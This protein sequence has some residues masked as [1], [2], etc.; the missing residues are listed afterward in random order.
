MRTE[1]RALQKI[2]EGREAEM[3]A[4]DEGQVLRLYRSGFSKVDAERQALLLRAARSAGVRVPAVYDVVDMDGRAGIILERLEGTDLMTVLGRQPW[5]LFGIARTTG[6]THARLNQRPAPDGLSPMRERLRRK[7][8]DSPAVPEEFR[9][10]ALRNLE[11][12]PDGDKLCHG[13]LWPG[14][15]MISGGEPV[16]IDWSNATRGDPDGDYA[17]SQMILEATEPPPWAP[18]LIRVSAKFARSVLIA[19]YMREYEKIR[20]PHKQRVADWGLPALVA[21]Y[22][23]GIAS[24]YPRLRR[25]IEKRLNR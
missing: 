8:A 20:R 16:V 2:A 1:S 10:P 13:D 5:R 22:D 3:F 14:N 4:W 11:G 21:R 12:Q 19:L 7:I 6:R 23:D 18:L 17:W 9:A 25:L 15:V 24:E